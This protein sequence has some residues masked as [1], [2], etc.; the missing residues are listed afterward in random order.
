M[1]VCRTAN[2]YQAAGVKRADGCLAG[3]GWPSEYQWVIGLSQAVTTDLI[4]GAS[5]SLGLYQPYMM[6]GQCSRLLQKENGGFRRRHALET[7]L[8]PRPGLLKATG[9]IE[10]HS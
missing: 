10:R 8:C 3:A 4:S 1:T 5:H 9:C 6:E 7:L 2:P